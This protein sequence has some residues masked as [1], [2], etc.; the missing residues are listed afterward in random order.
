MKRFIGLAAPLAVAQL[1]VHLMGLVDTLMAG[2]LGDR[3]LAALGLGNALFFLLLVAGSG[4]LAGLDT[5]IPRATGAGRQPVTWQL[6]HTGR[7]LAWGLGILLTLA[8]LG[9]R[10]VLEWLDIDATTANAAYFYILA[11]APSYV[12]LL[13]FFAARSFLQAGGRTRA[14]LVASVAGNVANAALDWIFIATFAR[15][16]T[17]AN[18]T[19]GLG[20][21]STLTAGLM[22]LVLHLDV[23]RLGPPRLA[24]AHH[25]RSFHALREVL[26]LGIPTS[27]QMMAE[28]GFFSLLALLATRASITVGASHQALMSIVSIFFTIAVA[29]SRAT[30]V[31]VAQQHGTGGGHGSRRLGGIG[32]VAIVVVM[33]GMCAALGAWAHLI[34]PVQLLPAEVL[35]LVE[36]LA[37]LAVLFLLVDGLQVVAAGALRGLGDASSPFW[38]TIAFHYA[39]ATPLL[40]GWALH[41]PHP[42]TAMWTVMTLSLSGAAIT[43][44]VVFVRRSTII[45]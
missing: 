13:L 20:A 22:L 17:A 1:G 10:V 39:F 6:L 5:L 34:S 40:L 43:M 16:T 8:A 27:L 24:G 2:T 41:E 30:T 26:A 32:M 21:S 29:F 37:P 38:V 4:V 25:G 19:L 45:H 42:L 35:A 18:A 15:Y 28:V 3:S 7:C 31:L 14:I 44:I 11:R 33:L 23:K 9:T 36:E 12:L